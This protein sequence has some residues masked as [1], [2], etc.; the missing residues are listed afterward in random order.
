[1]TDRTGALDARLRSL[2]SRLDT[3][4]GFDERVTARVLVELDVM[5]AQ[6][7]AQARAEEARR[8]ELAKRR[9]SWGAWIRG[10]V[11]LDTVG[12]AVFGGFIVRFLWTSAAGQAGE[13]IPLYARGVW[14][15]AA[16]GVLLALAA[17]LPALLWQHRRRFAGLA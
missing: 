14:A 2:L 3:S 16:L 15:W 6:R 1:M 10:R 4:P 13:L 5:T 11:T 12:A 8:Y 9:L 17:P 7:A